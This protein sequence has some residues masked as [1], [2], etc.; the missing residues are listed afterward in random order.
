S[1]VSGSLQSGCGGSTRAP[2]D[3]SKRRWAAADGGTKVFQMAGMTDPAGGQPIAALAPHPRSGQLAD[4]I[5]RCES[6]T[7]SGK[8][9]RCAG[10]RYANQDDLVTG[11]G[12]LRYGGRYSPKG[13]FCAVYGSLDL[14]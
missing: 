4:A 9:I 11:E 1:E 14:D 12:S 8:F 10:T 2:A 7:W 6:M 3:P 13:A 5:R